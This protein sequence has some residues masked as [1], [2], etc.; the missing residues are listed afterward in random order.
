MN[1]ERKASHCLTCGMSGMG[2]SSYNLRYIL[3]SWHDRIFI[4]D[5]QS[6]YSLRLNL[7]PCFTFAEARERA[8]SER[9]ICFDYSKNFFGEL[10]GS[11]NAF[12]DMV[13]FMC[14]DH[15]EPQNVQSLFV[16]DELQKII[17]A[18]EAPKEVKNIIQ[19]GRRFNLDSALMSQQP[20]RIGNEIREQVTELILFR[21]KEENSLKFVR[22]M[23]ID[24]DPIM[25]LP[26]LHYIW[27]D[28]V[29]G[30][31]RSGVIDY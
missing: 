11:L 10:E 25:S 20:N 2:K 23:G 26:P 31:Q 27:F 12:A 21:L 14:K 1:I 28:L 29:N 24:A 8:K 3:A 19:T 30:G 18:N 9:I 17:P 4:F 5:H 7:L 15:L 22:G 6:E 16:C 13:F